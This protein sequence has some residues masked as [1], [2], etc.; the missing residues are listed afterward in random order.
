MKLF[1]NK[2]FWRLKNGNERKLF[3]LEI[4][5][6]GEN[7]KYGRQNYLTC[8]NSL[9]DMLITIITSLNSDGIKSYA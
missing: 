6:H 7:L 9:I 4:K 5:L 2:I 3:D 1:L 8:K